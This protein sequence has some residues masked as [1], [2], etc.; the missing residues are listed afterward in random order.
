MTCVC[1]I[2]GSHTDTDDVPDEL[3]SQLNVLLSFARSHCH[4]SS[5]TSPFGFN[6]NHSQV[7]TCNTFHAPVALAIT[8]ESKHPSEPS[9]TVKV[10]SNELYKKKFS[11]KEI[12][13]RKRRRGHWIS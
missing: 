8:A 6:D 12:Y 4:N 11:Q 10:T 9:M 3:V 2:R 1:V 13:S 5:Y 7:N